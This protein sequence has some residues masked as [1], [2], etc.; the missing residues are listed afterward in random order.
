MIINRAPLPASI[1]RTTNSVTIASGHRRRFATCNPACH[2]GRQFFQATGPARE[3]L[4]IVSV[5][6]ASVALTWPMALLPIERRGL[7]TVTAIHVM[8]DDRFD[9]WIVQDDSG[10]ELGHYP[11]REAA[12]LVAHPLAQQRC[13]DLVI[14][15]PDGRTSRQSF[16]K[17][18]LAR[19]F[20]R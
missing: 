1:D 19:F 6:I 7:M 8:P 18:W 3:K 11:T 15:L 9:D 2:D 12:E 10:R 5:A 4:T 14:H 16:A 13:G 20:H 17:G